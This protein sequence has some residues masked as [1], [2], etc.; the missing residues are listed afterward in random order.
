MTLY[1]RSETVRDFNGVVVS[2]AI[3]KVVA[4]LV[5]SDLAPLATL[6]ADAAGLVPLTNPF[7]ADAAGQYSYWVD[8]GF[9]SEQVSRPGYYS[10]TNDGCF[11]GGVI[12]PAGPTGPTGPT[13]PQGAKGDQ[14]TGAVY[15]RSDQVATA[16]QTVFTVPTY[17]L[18]SGRCWFSKTA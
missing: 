16:G 3:I 12:G 8:T 7:Q 15:L 13:G 4:G 10:E 9:Y 17:T 5:Y 11:M 1:Q 2:K 18:E 6:Y 14:G